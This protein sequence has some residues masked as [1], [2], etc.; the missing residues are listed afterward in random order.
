MY[1]SS[2]VNYAFNEQCCMSGHTN[3]VFYLRYTYE[4][5]NIESVILVS[6]L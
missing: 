2:H 5:Q 1:F 4:Y 3:T 6:F